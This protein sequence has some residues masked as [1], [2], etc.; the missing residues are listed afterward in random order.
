[1]SSVFKFLLMVV[2]SSAVT[3]GLIWTAAPTNGAVIYRCDWAEISPD[4]PAKVKEECR[5]RI[6]RGTI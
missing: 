5:K 3:A 6:F 4:I 1:M 2:I